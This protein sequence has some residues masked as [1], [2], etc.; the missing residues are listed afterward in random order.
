MSNENNKKKKTVYVDD[1]RTI[2]DMSAFGTSQKTRKN[3]Q[4]NAR[5][6]KIRTYFESVK[7]M[8]LPMLNT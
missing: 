5:G 4:S 1:G 8:L 6:G 7:M 3:L 2:V